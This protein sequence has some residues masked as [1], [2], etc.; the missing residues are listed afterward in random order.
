MISHIVRPGPMS[1]L[2]ACGSLR[3]VR[4]AIGLMTD[5]RGSALFE[6]RRRAVRRKVRW[7]AAVIAVDGSW[8]H[9]CTIIDV[10]ASGAQVSLNAAISLPGEFFLSFT[11][12]GRVSR[13]CELVWRADK[14]VGVR[15]AHEG[16]GAELGSPLQV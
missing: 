11:K 1:R 2:F 7:Q 8:Q 5:A 6:N 13:L 10:S 9:K 15:F 3:V 16:R 12:D 14:K 4:A